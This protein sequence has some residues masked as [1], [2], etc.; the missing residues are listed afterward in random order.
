MLATFPR[1]CAE[2]NSHRRYEKAH[3]STHE[4]PQTV[5]HIRPALE[6][7]DDERTFGGEGKPVEATAD[8]ALVCKALGDGGRRPCVIDSF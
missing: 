7:D 8:H 3:V 5:T 1:P 4:M 6:P 2:V